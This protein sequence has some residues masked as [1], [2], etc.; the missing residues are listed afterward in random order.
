MKRLFL[1]LIMAGFTAGAY[2]QDGATANSLASA[3]V[4]TPISITKDVD[5]SFGNVAVN[6]VSGGTVVLDTNDGTTATGDVTLPATAGTV[7]SGAFTVNGETGYTYAITLPT[8]VN[9]TDAVSSE[10]MALSSFTSLPEATGVLTGGTEA[11]KVGATL[12]VGAGQVSGAYAGSFD[13]TVNYN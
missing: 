8:T 6:S 12:T 4:V 3:T 11:L 5:L 13:V 9:I 1:L 2:A 7:T 10:I